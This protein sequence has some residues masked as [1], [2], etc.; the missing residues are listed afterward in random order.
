MSRFVVE[1]PKLV[2]EALHSS[3]SVDYVIIRSSD[4]GMRELLAAA[5]EAGATVYE[6]DART[7]DS[8]ADSQTPQPA[9]AV[10]Q[11][12]HL[13]L[14]ERLNPTE[15]RSGLLVLADVA[16]PGNVG[17]LIRTSEAAGMSGVALVGSCAD[18]LGPKVVRASAGSALRV[19][20]AELVDGT[21][22]EIVE[23]LRPF[24]DAVVATA[25]EGSSFRELSGS[26]VAYVLGSEAH[27]VRPD[28][29]EACDQIV[30]IPMHG[31]AESLNVA[32]AGAV[33]AFH[34]N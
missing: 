29:I 22:T 17:T 11:A 3:L 23:Q 15:G 16:D 7:F 4:L 27:G 2:I 21:G 31:A 30:C 10:V 14:D 25:M 20:V 33:L 26:N 28:L 12:P 34:R 8:L 1:T 24:V 13:L 32:A 19:P 6:L 5:D 18:V 9:L